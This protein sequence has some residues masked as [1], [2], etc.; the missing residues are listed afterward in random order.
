MKER[1]QIIFNELKEFFENIDKNIKIEFNEVGFCAKSGEKIDYIFTTFY[2]DYIYVDSIEIKEKCKGIGSNFLNK[3]K[4]IVKK[5][6]FKYIRLT[7]VEN[8]F[9]FYLKCDFMFETVFFENDKVFKNVEFDLC[10]NQDIYCFFRKEVVFNL[11]KEFFVKRFKYIDKKYLISL[12]YLCEIEIDD[13]NEETKLI[14]GYRFMNMM[15]ENYLTG[16]MI[17]LNK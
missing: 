8:S 1:N 6:N 14:H 15:F 3:L 16:D 17:W 10:I 4:E 5:F 12:Y 9:L 7:Y 13:L 2:D 11:I